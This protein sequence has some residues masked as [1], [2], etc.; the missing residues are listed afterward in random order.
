M[1]E[2]NSMLALNNRNR[3]SFAGEENFEKMNG[4]RHIKDFTN[5]ELDWTGWHFEKPTISSSGSFWYHAVMYLNDQQPH[6]L[7]DRELQIQ[8]AKTDNTNRRYC[9]IF[10]LFIVQVDPERFTT[11]SVF[12]DFIHNGWD[13]Y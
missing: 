7:R 12:R 13:V 9:R 3:P 1:Y 8:Y 11:R 10:V 5:I 2:N 4:K 6:V